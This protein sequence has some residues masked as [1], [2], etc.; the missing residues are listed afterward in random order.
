[1]RQMRLFHRRVR[2][3][4]RVAGADRKSEHVL[5]GQYLQSVRVL[6]R[7]VRRH[8][9][10]LAHGQLPERMDARDRDGE[11]RGHGETNRRIDIQSAL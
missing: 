5:G 3:C 1:M 2:R 4:F 7:T 6:G 10:R 11:F 9:H 8:R